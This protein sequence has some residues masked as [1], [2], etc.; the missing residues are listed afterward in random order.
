MSELK[1][2]EAFFKDLT[3]PH[4]R[5]IDFLRKAFA[6]GERYHRKQTRKQSNQPYFTHPIAVAE[7]LKDYDDTV[8]AAALLHD[9]LEDTKLKR[10]DLE[11]EMGTEVSLLIDGMTKNEGG[12]IFTNLVPVA[13]EDERVLFIKLADRYHN[14][15]DNIDKMPDTTKMKY[16]EETPKL[17]Q[18]ALDFGILF[19]TK[20]LGTELQKLRQSL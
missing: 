4:R 17:I 15:T 3:V 19:L 13:Q 11:K 16:L 18:M 6:L 2:F 7:L 8:I 10:K 12:T 1:S 14:L 9:T 20:E 5:N